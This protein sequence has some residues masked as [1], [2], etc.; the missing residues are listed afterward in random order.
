MTQCSIDDSS[1]LPLH[2]SSVSGLAALCSGPRG[3]KVSAVAIAALKVVYCNLP[4]SNYFFNICAGPQRQKKAVRN[5]CGLVPY[6]LLSPPASRWKARVCFPHFP[7]LLLTDR[8]EFDLD[9]FLP[10]HKKEASPTTL[11]SFIS[12]SLSLQ[13]ALS[14]R[15]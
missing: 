1:Q 6:R 3:A 12:L 14:G 15:R 4:A 10:S 8:S 11:I 2:A 7:S 5:C 13:L 9:L